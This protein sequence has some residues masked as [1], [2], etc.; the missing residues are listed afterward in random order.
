[1]NRTKRKVSRDIGIEVA[2]LCGKYFLKSP[3]L[4]YG[5]WTSNLE[6]DITNLRIAQENYARFII[7]HIP[8]GVRKILD[9]GCGSGQIAKTLVEMGY[10]V[11][12]VSPSSYLSREAHELL[13]ETSHIFEYYYEELQTE[14]RYDLILFS[15][16]FQYIDPEEA[17]KKTVEF[18]NQSGYVLICDIFKRDIL[19]KD[20]L[21]G[22]HAL[23]RFYEI[24]SEYSLEPVMDLDITEQTAPNLDIANDM[25]NGVIKPT[26]DLAEQLLDNRYPF[27]SK[28]LKFLY[29]KR[30]KKIHEKYFNGVKTGGNFKKFKSYRLLL[31]RK[32]SQAN[33]QQVDF[34]G[35]CLG[36]VDLKPGERIKVNA[37]T[38][39]AHPKWLDRTLHYMANLGQIWQ[40]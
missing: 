33:V 32:W 5:Y 25:L 18:L 9:V 4:H 35:P 7:S 30:I 11:D 10:E 23:T 17:I 37:I 31:Y 6:V 39:S 21:S 36:T 22:G 3:H 40:I 8:D 27:M 2:S 12:C 29:R 13:G 19:G 28:V 24:I 15:E 14:N 38:T 20:P 16:S 1:M 26:I 34:T